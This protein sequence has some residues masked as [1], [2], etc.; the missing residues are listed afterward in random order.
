MEVSDRLV[1]LA[2]ANDV[3]PKEVAQFC[4]VSNNTVSKWFLGTAVP[5]RGKNLENLSKLFK[6][7]KSYIAFGIAGDNTEEHVLSEK[8]KMLSGKERLAV[9]EI[10]DCLIG[11][12]SHSKSQE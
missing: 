12:R 7:S 4:G 11:G 6:V 9:N 1:A 3:S 5:T 10:V 2:K 8:I